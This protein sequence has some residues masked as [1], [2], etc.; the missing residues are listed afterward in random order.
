MNTDLHFSSK[1][2]DWETPPDLF[3]IWNDEFHFVLDV[4]A[5]ADTKKCA[6]YYGPDHSDLS[7]RDGLQQ[8]WTD[9]A[10][11][12]FAWMNPP[13]GR[14][15]PKWIE[16]A[17]LEAIEGCKIVCLVPARTDTKW[18]HEYVLNGPSAQLEFLRGRIKFVGAQHSAPFPSMLVVYN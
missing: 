11:G 6:N 10:Q 1:N 7:K 2:L 15:I 3:S 18:F 8:C 4:C 14:E 17:Y 16:K 9:D 13:Y 5:T 12:G